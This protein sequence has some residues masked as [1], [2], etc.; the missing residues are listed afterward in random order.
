M[1]I[2]K[3]GRE[4]GREVMERELVTE[5]QLLELLNK[6]IQRLP[7]CD[8]TE[9]LGDLSPLENGPSGRNW[10][11][12]DPP[13]LRSLIT[14]QPGNAKLRCPS[15]LVIRSQARTMAGWCRSPWTA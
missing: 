1:I 13:R 10:E 3:G 8:G 14:H 7:D 9:I 2:Y 11:L 5:Q 6:E 4:E 15:W 12:N